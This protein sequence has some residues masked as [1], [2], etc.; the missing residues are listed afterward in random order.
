MH[1]ILGVGQND[2]LGSCGCPRIWHRNS[3]TGGGRGIRLGVVGKGVDA[4]GRSDAYQHDDFEDRNRDPPESNSFGSKRR[5][6]VVRAEIVL[7]RI[8]QDGVLSTTVLL[9]LLLKTSREKD[10]EKLCMCPH[11]TLAT[12]SLLLLNRPYIDCPNLASHDKEVNVCAAAPR[13]SGFTLF[14]VPKSS[15]LRDPGLDMDSCGKRYRCLQSE[16]DSS[17]YFHRARFPD[18]SNGCLDELILCV[19]RR[20]GACKDPR[21]PSWLVQLEEWQG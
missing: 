19:V 21:D 15:R 10:G 3:D 2:C 6:V 1:T 16:C 17:F 13:P 14:N 9:E 18:F 11:L 5:E 7:A 12:I 4:E 20:L 8:P